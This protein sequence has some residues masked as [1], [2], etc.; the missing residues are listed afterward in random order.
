MRISYCLTL[1]LAMLKCVSCLGQARDSTDVKWLAPSKVIKFSPLHLMN[2][3][4][5][6]EL[7]YEHRVADRFTLQGEFGYVLDYEN[8]TDTEFKDKRG[9]KA[10]LEPR[11]Y[12]AYS[13]KHMSFYT[14]A[15]VYFNH[16]NFDR[17]TYVNG[18][19]DQRCD[20]QFVQRTNFEVKY[21]EHGASIKLGWIIHMHRFLFDLNS[22]WTVR[23]I[24]YSGQHENFDDMVEVLDF[25]PNEADRTRLSPNLGIRFGYRLE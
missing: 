24:R 8:N 9:F 15:E 16:I 2:F 5:T 3:Y 10:K 11:Y 22:G 23:F 7:S 13:E 14:S 1:V 17:E 12:L 6:I 25:G 21:R 18:C 20:F 4:P 19:I